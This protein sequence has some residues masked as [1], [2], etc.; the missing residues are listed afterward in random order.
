PLFPGT[1]ENFILTASTLTVTSALNLDP[2]RSVPGAVTFSPDGAVFA[3]G[4]ANRVV[5]FVGFASLNPA[6]SNISFNADVNGL[7]YS[8]DG[9]EIAVAGGFGSPLVGLYDVATHGLRA[10]RMPTYDTNAVAFSPDG[11]ALL[12]GEADCGKVFVCAD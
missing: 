11:K 10:Q 3:V 2:N 1:A 9:T 8:P 6:G 12:G 5:R 7:A 4:I